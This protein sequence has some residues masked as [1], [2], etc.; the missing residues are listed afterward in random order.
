MR[1]VILGGAAVDFGVVGACE[2]Y[3][4]VKTISV[5]DYFILK[6]KKNTGN[7]FKPTI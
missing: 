7:I 6:K 3:P 1:V 5:E 4:S 2:L